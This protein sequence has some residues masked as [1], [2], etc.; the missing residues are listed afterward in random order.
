MSAAVGTK[1]RTKVPTLPAHPIPQV[2]LLPPEVFTSR[3]VDAV[4][5]ATITS[6]IVS[7]LLVAGGYGFALLQRS[8]ANSHLAAETVTTERLLAEQEKYAEVPRILNQQQLIVGTRTEAFTSDVDWPVYFDA[9]VAAMPQDTQV[10]AI[11]VASGTALTGAVPALDTLVE[12]GVGQMKITARS[13]TV[14]DAGEIVTALSEIQ[15]FADVRASSVAVTE[16][17][18][19]GTYYSVVLTVQLNADA[20]RTDR[21]AD[22]EDN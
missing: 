22:G 19:E 1:H 15:G 2:D 13:T 8:I 14:P 7:A 17:S 18:D 11:E 12:A 21:F 20:I 6:L 10:A 9:V 16:D 5:R 4:K 3:K